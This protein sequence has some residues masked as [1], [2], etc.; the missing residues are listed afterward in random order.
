[1]YFYFNFGP[2][3]TEWIKMSVKIGK[4][5]SSIEPL[6]KAKGVPQGAVLSPLLFNLFISDIAN[7]ITEDI[8]IKQYAD[9]IKI[10]VMYSKVLHTNVGLSS[11][12]S[13]NPP[14]SLICSHL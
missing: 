3:T 4:H 10:Y 12:N 2:S 1:M 14:T 11:S 9:D 7:I 5:H 13:L 6:P 8:T